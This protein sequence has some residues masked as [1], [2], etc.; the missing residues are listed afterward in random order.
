MTGRPAGVIAC[1]ACSSDMVEREDAA[2]CVACGAMYPVISGIPVMFGDLRRYMSQRRSVGEQMMRLGSGASRDMVAAAMPEDH[3]ADASG[4][5]ERRWAAIYQSNDNTSTYRHILD[6]M[7]A[8]AGLTVLEHGCSVGVMSRLLN[9]AGA[10]VTGVDTSFPALRMAAQQTRCVR[11]AVADSMSL[12][13]GT[14]DAV[15]ALNVLE[16]IEPRALL[17]A[18]ADR[19]ARYV[20]VADPYDYARGSRSVARPVGAAA[21]RKLLDASGFEVTAETRKPSFVPWNL[22]ISSRVTLRYLLDV[23]IAKRV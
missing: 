10:S 5:A 6:A 17:G 11:Y 8:A 3:K 9:D 20:V 16:L 19:A 22:R 15:V 1:T 2:R 4:S 14:F 13:C 21:V 18:M 12:S 7:P 23:I